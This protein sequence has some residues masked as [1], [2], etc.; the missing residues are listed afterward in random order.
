MRLLRTT[1]MRELALEPEP[2]PERAGDVM[3]S[4]S[5]AYRARR[6]WLKRIAASIAAAGGFALALVFV[7]NDAQAQRCR[8]CGI[9]AGILGGLAAGVII[10]GAIAGAAAPP[11]RPYVPPYAPAPGRL[12]YPSYATPG[13]VRPA[14]SPLNCSAANVDVGNDGDPNMVVS[15]FVAR[16]PGQWV[17][18]HTLADAT[19]VDRWCWSPGI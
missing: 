2:E 19:V 14:N 9:D 18:K 10:G 12:T 16:D 8:G 17:I 5:V 11:Y 13:A 4:G 1:Y 3:S 15:T 6:R 7:V